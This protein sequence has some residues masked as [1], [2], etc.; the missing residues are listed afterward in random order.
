MKTFKA[1]LILTFLSCSFFA[2]A[3]NYSC[4][5][6]EDTVSPNPKTYTDSAGVTHDTQPWIN[7]KNSHP[8]HSIS[9]DWGCCDKLVREGDTCK[10]K[11]IVDESLQTCSNH[12]SC[13]SGLGCYKLRADEDLFNE[14]NS[15]GSSDSPQLVAFEKQ[16]ETELGEDEDLKENGEACYR[17]L[18][19]SSYSCEKFKC[20]DRFICREGD[21]DEIAPG[22]IK[23]E[24]SLV[25]DPATGKCI[26][27]GVNFYS[28]LIGEVAVQQLSGQQCQ[29]QVV[30]ANPALTFKDLQ[31]AVNL[32]VV[33]LRSMEW[34]FSSASGANHVE[35]QFV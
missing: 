4:I 1:F 6:R 31:H 8:N 35:C 26:S 34:L 2:Q 32:S 33:S 22:N 10:D 29:F 21:L 18:E 14:D 11:S 27:A 15:E 23:C 3:F 20:V 30:P 16:Q 24:D 17:N 28:G 7:W 19:C 5:G 25:K 13:P 9:K 12:G